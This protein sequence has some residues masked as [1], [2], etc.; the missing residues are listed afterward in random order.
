[1]TISE[2]P[3][4]AFT[5]VTPPWKLGFQSNSAAGGYLKFC[6]SS[7]DPELHLEVTRLRKVCWK[8]CRYWSPIH[9][10]I[11]SL[12]KLNSL[13]WWFCFVRKIRGRGLCPVLGPEIWLTQ[14]AANFQQIRTNSVRN[15][16][17]SPCSVLDQDVICHLPEWGVSFDPYT[18][19]WTW[20]SAASPVFK[21]FQIPIICSVV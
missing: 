4:S 20:F 18:I 16:T 1:M 9:L 10:P 11:R 5:L 17:L 8:M 13:R 2:M 19:K 12:T 15:K 14:V 3:D 7:F 6:C 21:I